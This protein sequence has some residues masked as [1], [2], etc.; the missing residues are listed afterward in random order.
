MWVC[1][2]SSGC[3]TPLGRGR[4]WLRLALMQKKLSDYM[5][6]IINRK[7]LLRCVGRVPPFLHWPLTVNDAAFVSAANSMSQTRW[8]WRRREPSSRGCSSGWTSSMPI[9]VW[10]ERTWTLRC[11]DFYQWCSSCI[12]TLNR[13]RPASFDGWSPCFCTAGR[14]DWFFHVPQ[15]WGTQQ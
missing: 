14:C 11:F 15:R 3:R 10:R 5:K 12:K 9:C 6:T 4:A 1:F 2:L 13:K 7:D 8:W